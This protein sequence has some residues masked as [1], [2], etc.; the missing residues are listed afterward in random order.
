MLGNEGSCQ[1]VDFIAGEMM[2]IW[3]RCLHSVLLGQDLGP[4]VSGA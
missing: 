4:G 2:P 1:L 3:N